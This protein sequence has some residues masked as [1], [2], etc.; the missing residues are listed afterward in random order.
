MNEITKVLLKT[1][2]TNEKEI[3]NNLDKIL[4]I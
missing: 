2:N 1:I 3:I 4:L